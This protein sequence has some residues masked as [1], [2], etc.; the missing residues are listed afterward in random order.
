MVVD[1]DLFIGLQGQLLL[2]FWESENPSK[3]SQVVGNAQCNIS[4]YPSER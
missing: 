2:V 3:S 1:S 4:T